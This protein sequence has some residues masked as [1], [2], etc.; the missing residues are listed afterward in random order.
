MFHFKTVCVALKRKKQ[1]ASVEAEEK[2]R[3]FF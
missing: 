1:A 2:F 3:I